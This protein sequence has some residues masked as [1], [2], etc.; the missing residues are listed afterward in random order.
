[1]SALSVEQRRELVA[2][3]E[4]EALV[5]DLEQRLAAAKARSH[6]L[7]TVVEQYA[8]L[9]NRQVY[10]LERLEQH[11]GQIA[12]AL[13]RLAEAADRIAVVVDALTIYASTANQLAAR[14]WWK[15]LLGRGVR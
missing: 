7:E 9:D 1:M 3:A 14:S 6:E 12:S 8:D 15:R 4:Y 13:V 5:E 2:D 10:R 11:Q